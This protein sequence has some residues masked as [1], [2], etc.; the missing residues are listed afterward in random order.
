MRDEILLVSLIGLGGN[1]ALTC[2]ALITSY[3]H[4]HLPEWPAVNLHSQLW[5]SNICYL[6]KC[7]LAWISTI[8]WESFFS[9]FVF[10]GQEFSK[11]YLYLQ[12]ALCKDSCWGS[13]G[14]IA[15]GEHFPNF[16][17]KKCNKVK[18]LLLP[19][20]LPL[21]CSLRQTI[22]LTRHELMNKHKFKC[23]ADK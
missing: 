20:P 11:F 22:E 10:S 9:V 4:Y 8:F 23:Q 6:R 15:F 14:I 1:N 21:L 3:C 7:G 2:T 12:S 19:F 5:V 16:A 18:P 13:Q 17:L